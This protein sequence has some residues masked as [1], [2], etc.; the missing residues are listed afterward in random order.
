MDGSYAHSI[1]TRARSLNLNTGKLFK[2]DYE[3]RPFW[4]S[5]QEKADIRPKKCKIVDQTKTADKNQC[6][7]LKTK[8]MVPLV[9][10]DLFTSLV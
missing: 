8:R 7:P 4:F 2:N 5:H 1:C 6:L 9:W 10:H 3:P